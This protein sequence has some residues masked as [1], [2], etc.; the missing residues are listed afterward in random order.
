MMTQD[1]YLAII[2]VTLPL[3]TMAITVAV[4]VLKQGWIKKKGEG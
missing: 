1:E 2:C 4:I 3:V